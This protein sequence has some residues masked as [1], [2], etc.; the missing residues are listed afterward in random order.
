MLSF[1]LSS[2]LF[3]ALLLVLNVFFNWINCTL[4]KFPVLNNLGVPEEYISSLGTAPNLDC[5]ELE[6]PVDYTDPRG[7]KITLGMTRY[8]ITI[9]VKRY[10]SIIYNPGGPGG[11]GSLSAISQGLG[12]PALRTQQ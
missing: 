8:R 11:A 7:E 9:L 1:L 4:E 6:V 10:G 12:V 2:M 5:A 3:L